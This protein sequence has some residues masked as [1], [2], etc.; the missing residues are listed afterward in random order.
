MGTLRALPLNIVKAYEDKEDTVNLIKEVIKKVSI[1]SIYLSEK[2]LT[3][4][5]S[6]MKILNRAAY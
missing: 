6:Q 2:S 4:A 1:R 5:S 3:F